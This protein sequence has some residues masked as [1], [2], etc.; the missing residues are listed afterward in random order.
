MPVFE[1]GYAG[2]APFGVGD[3]LDKRGFLFANRV[4]RLDAVQEFGLVEC[5]VVSGKQ[6]GVAGEA[7][8]E[9]GPVESWALA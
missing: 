3:G 1:T 7:S 6:D 4:E 5:G 8:V 9:V 2:D